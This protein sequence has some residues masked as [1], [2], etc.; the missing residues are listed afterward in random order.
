MYYEEYNKPLEKEGET[1]SESKH[2]I[3]LDVELI[4]VEM[5]ACNDDALI[6]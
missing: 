3:F 5:V 4:S 1:L 2:R 6:S